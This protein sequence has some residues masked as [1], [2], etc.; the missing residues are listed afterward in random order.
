MAI[1]KLKTVQPY[2]D[3]CWQGKKT[4]EVRF[5]D[6]N[7][8]VDDTVYL[9]EYDAESKAFSG[10]KLRTTIVYILENYPALLDKYVVF[11]FIVDAHMESKPSFEY[12]L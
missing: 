1:H 7:F 4:F 6:R 11:S 12:S 5:N 2:F 8:Q 3:N 9:M 10:R